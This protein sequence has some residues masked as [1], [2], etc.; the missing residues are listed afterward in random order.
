MKYRIMLPADYTM[1][2]RRYPVLYLL[3]GLTGSYLDWETRTHLVDYVQP[4]PLIVVMPDAG[5]SWYTNS[6]GAPQDKFEDY[7]VK[8]LIAEVDKNYRTLADRH[9][10]AIAGLSMGGY[11][12]L[13][14]ALKYPAL[15]FFAGSLSGAEAPVHDPTHNVPFGQKYI[16]GMRTIFGN[17]ATPT[18]AD[19]DIFAL[20][21][22]ADGAR[23][24][25]LY[26]ACGTEDGL[27]Q[28]NRDFVTL[29]QKQKIRYEYR[30]SRG[31]HSWEYW[32]RELPGLL[33]AMERE[34]HGAR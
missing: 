25:Y 1:T 7:I 10:R 2:A 15:F 5:D 23:V 33:Q 28:S 6:A 13:K 16:D 32:D 24:P 3:H 4:L 8:D 14:F 29:V 22:K 19:N 18:L 27:L 26:V 31:A 21:T 34:M 9:G 12:A 11:G 20:V 30:E 17:G